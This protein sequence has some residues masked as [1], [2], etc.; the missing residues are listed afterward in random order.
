MIDEHAR[1]GNT[2]CLIGHECGSYSGHGGIATYMALTAKGLAALGLDVHVIYVHGP[3]VDVPGVRSWKIKD[4]YDPVGNSDAVDRLLEKI[5][6]DIVECAEFHGLASCTLKRRALY[7]LD[8][9]CTFVTLHH[10]GVREIWTWGTRLRFNQC[11]PAEWQTLHR[12]ERTQALLSDA[13]FSPSEFLAEYLSRQYD[14]KYHVCPSCYRPEVPVVSERLPRND[15]NLLKVISLGRF[16]GR[17][18]QDLL[19][20]AACTLLVE[21]YNIEVTF[22]GNSEGDFC[23]GKDIR[24]TCYGLIP[25]SLR[26]KFHFYDFIPHQALL[27]H[28][29][30][31]DLFVIPSP[32]ENFPYAALEAISAGVMVVGSQTSGIRDM[33]GSELSDFGFA[34]GSVADIKRVILKFYQLS[35]E[36]KEKV[37]LTQLSTLRELTSAKRSLSDRIDA[38]RQI[39]IRP[40]NPHPD[41]DNILVVYQGQN[42]FPLHLQCG[43]SEFALEG[44]GWKVCL[45]HV[46]HVILVSPGNNAFGPYDNYYPAPGVVAFYSSNKRND[47][48]LEKLSDTQKTFSRLILCTDGIP[49][50]T[51]SNV[52]EYIASLLGNSHDLIYFTDTRKYKEAKLGA[53]IQYALARIKYGYEDMT[54]L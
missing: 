32:Y 27:R 20:R 34:P 42:G 24:E 48:T 17:K 30:T 43:E 10:T 2:I 35:W 52:V 45:S 11:A 31:Y 5:R 6:P 4:C 37:R 54:C 21:G 53:G 49:L 12:L 36:Q 3:G 46:T 44:D 18:R 40:R 8:W 16:E 19:I 15:G 50:D 7:G 9:Q 25:P 22:I 14:E 1:N 51:C 33:S 47:V 28:Y 26:D 23:T 13:N 38:Y 29:S 41:P 39:T